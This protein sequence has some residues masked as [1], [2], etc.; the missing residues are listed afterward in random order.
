MRTF[1]RSFRTLAFG[2]ALA[3]TVIGA[4][5]TASHTTWADTRTALV[6]VICRGVPSLHRD[7][8]VQIIILQ[9]FLGGPFPTN[10]TCDPNDP[11]TRVT[12][13]QL[14]GLGDPRDFPITVELFVDGAPVI[15][16][17]FTHNGGTL[18]YFDPD[19]KLRIT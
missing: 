17:R 2:L 1:S 18:Q 19:T 15:A 6:D 12:R 11:T 7:P 13:Y 5:L 10:L 4:V 14:S 9:P 3:A 8:T 16:G